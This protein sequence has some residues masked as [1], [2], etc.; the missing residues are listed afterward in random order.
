MKEFVRTYNLL[1]LKTIINE[2]WKVFFISL[3]QKNSFIIKGNK[4]IIIIVNKYA[5]FVVYIIIYKKSPTSN[6]S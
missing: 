6:N 2:I 5:N 4:M 3:P 1:V